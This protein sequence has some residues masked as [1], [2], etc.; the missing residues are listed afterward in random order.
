MGIYINMSLQDVSFNNLSS[1]TVQYTMDTSLCNTDQIT[2]CTDLSSNTSDISLPT[3][4]ETE[5]D[6]SYSGC[7]CYQLCIQI[8]CLIMEDISM[9]TTD[10]SGYGYN[11]QTIACKYNHGILVQTNIGVLDQSC[12]P[13]DIIPQSTM[14]SVETTPYDLRSTYIKNDTNFMTILDDFSMMDDDTTM[15]ENNHDESHESRIVEESFLEFTQSLHTAT[16]K[17]RKK[18]THFIHF[19]K[20]MK[21]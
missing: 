12:A 19:P 6:S 10:M 21:K 9:I 5:M 14:C 3:T 13:I 15:D 1:H 11:I 7:A 4:Y 20:D 17:L 2:P 18:I 8:P 16:S